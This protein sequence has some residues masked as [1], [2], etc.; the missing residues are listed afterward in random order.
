MFL[1]S[2]SCI[3][4]CLITGSFCHRHFRLAVPVVYQNKC[5][6]FKTSTITRI[7]DFKYPKSKNLET[8]VESFEIQI[9]LMHT[10]IN[11]SVSIPIHNASCCDRQLML[12]CSV[13]LF[14]RFL[15]RL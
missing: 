14:L 6:L 10:A 8:L 1:S 4:I 13:H 9:L 2:N 15:L 3:C 11:C 12:I 7:K 5:I